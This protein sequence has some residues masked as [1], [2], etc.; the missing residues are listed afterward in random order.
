MNEDIEAKFILEYGITVDEF[1]KDMF[2]DSD[3]FPEVIETKL[4]DFEDNNRDN[5]VEALRDE[6]GDITYDSTIEYFIHPDTETEIEYEDWYDLWSESK[7]VIVD[8]LHDEC[9]NLINDE[10]DGD[11]YELYDSFSNFVTNY[12]SEIIEDDWSD[13]R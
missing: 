8:E 13:N 7:D 4:L 3:L 10:L 5:V 6:Y 12:L 9:M 2:I 1:I 11:Y